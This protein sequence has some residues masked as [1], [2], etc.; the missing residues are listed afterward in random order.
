MDAQEKDGGQSQEVLTMPT[1]LDW[2]LPSII[3]CEK[4]LSG[5]AKLYI[6]GDKSLGLK[7]HFIPI[8][9]D[10][11]SDFKFKFKLAVGDIRVT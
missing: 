1:K 11:R 9:K 7:K 10:A 4:A 3:Q 6:E 2:C 8:Y 5:M